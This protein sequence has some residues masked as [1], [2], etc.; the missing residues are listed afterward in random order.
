MK[1]LHLFAA[2]GLLIYIIFVWF[3]AG[4]LHLG[5]S[6]L[7]I[8]RV[9]LWL[10]GIAATALVVYF[11]TKGEGEAAA[12]V[13][14]EADL[15][16]D[17]EFLVR[18]AN[19]GLAASQNI[20]KGGRHVSG[21]PL[22]LFL[23]D[24]GAAKTT[25]ILNSGLEPELMAGQVF[26]DSAV[27][28]TQVANLWL[29]GK[30]ILV[31]AGGPLA[32][33]SAGFRR[34]L[35][36]LRGRTLANLVGRRGQSPR[37][38]VICYDSANFTISDS[39]S[40]VDQAARRLR[41]VLGEIA[42]RWG[43]RLPIYVLFTKLDQIPFF[44]DYFHNLTQEESSQLFGVTLRMAPGDA[45][46]VYSEQQTRRLTEAFESLF[47]S[48]SDRRLDYLRRENDSAKALNGYEFPREFRKMRDNL[49][50]FLVEVG[51]PSQLRASPFL[52]GFYF[53]G[54]RPLVVS[55]GASAPEPAISEPY[56]DDAGATRLFGSPVRGPSQRVPA[57]S[58]S[59]QSRRIPQWVFL[60]PF[61]TKVLLADRS[62]LGVSGHD[63]RASLIRRGIS[64][65]AAS[66]L[67]I[68]IVGTTVSYSNNRE[69]L[70]QA[71]TASGSLA[72]MRVFQD[73]PPSA[74]TLRQ[75]EQLR[76]V[77]EAAINHRRYGV[78]MS[79]RWGLYPGADLYDR[80]TSLYCRNFDR[81]L[82]SDA[83]GS[84]AEYFRRLPPAP[85]QGDD[86][87]LPFRLLR[88]YLMTTSDP[89]KAEPGFL[90]RVLIDRWSS[91]RVLSE[92]ESALIRQQFAFY[93]SERANDLCPAKA[94]PDAVAHVRSYLWQF[95]PV[96]R[97]YRSMLGEV[98]KRGQPY[99]FVD[100]AGA[101]IDKQQVIFPYTKPGWGAMQ[102]AVLRST[103]Y[104][105]RDPWVFGEQNKGASASTL[106]LQ[107]QL[108][109]RYAAD[110]L[111]QWQ[112]FLNQAAV[113]TYSGFSDASRKLD[114]ITTAQSSLLR[115]FCGISMNT[116]VEAPEI[117]KAFFSIQQ[118]Q[119]PASCENKL[120]DTATQPYMN[121]MTALKFQVDELS[122]NP[123]PA[124]AKLDSTNA[125]VT[126]RTT[127]QSL[128]L[129]PKAEQL[130]Q[131]PILNA[132]AVMSKMAP[133]S[134]N[135]K[136]NDFCRTA[137]SLFQRF[138][139]GPRG[140]T[141]AALSDFNAVF[142]PGTGS[143]AMF[144]QN[145]LQELVAPGPPVVRK[146]GA[147][148]S[149]RPDFLIFL[150]RAMAISR[151]FF[152]GNVTRPALSYFVQSTQSTNVD[153][154]ILQI[155]GKSLKGGGTSER[156]EFVWT[157]DG[158]AVSLTVKP[159]S[160]ATPPAIIRSGVWALFQ[161]LSDAD[162][163]SAGGTTYE[164]DIRG[165]SSIGRQATST[166][167]LAVLRLQVEAKGAP[168]FFGSFPAAC[169]SRVAQ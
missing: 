89:S 4:W 42:H 143:L 34:A 45:A 90:A 126:A 96:E 36:L 71:A 55:D 111:A 59:P 163:V 74:E 141:D 19:R 31:E 50:R 165:S 132:E 115:L 104:Y 2:L 123:N 158:A 133:V 112:Q 54:V 168:G 156:Q 153:S 164:Y 8:L 72:R 3:L 159:R 110:Y 62:A 48:L 20:R 160:G 84:L 155:G 95:Q 103:D 113:A 85:G 98:S 134:V 127:A 101:V 151:A 77:A 52:R 106:E 38:V 80:S 116:N 78:P 149:V 7:W 56:A 73:Q 87:E 137:G 94:D 86:Y 37:A 147:R 11:V 130:L 30:A 138:P 28:P 136:G 109:Q 82:L 105:G 44:L 15:R 21:L 40:A 69:L 33:S 129:P 92:D 122:R 97:I 99:V 63:T 146:A 93:A 14:G 57:R 144:Y 154:F 70:N 100:P 49:V 9:A 35:E 102:N 32:A 148:V 1:R 161:L 61:F 88:A 41:A 135:G 27:I 108:R 119:P 24:T 81:T 46:G 16:G 23:G 140:S 166:G 83:R 157:G 75:L 65:A 6:S 66:L 47:G 142:Q 25:V 64:F 22:V 114:S 67:L 29:G 68:W 79:L 18:E 12:P 76:E 131:D 152:P 125:K 117:Q 124:D 17:V 10:I 139:F 26:K 60:S 150:N 107:Q 167:P 128:N 5:A 169:V 13:A 43:S 121:A 145:S 118:L 162:R 53:T 51:R 58:V 120:N 39:R 91:N